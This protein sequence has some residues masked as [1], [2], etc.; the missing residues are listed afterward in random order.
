M[1]EQISMFDFI[2][3]PFQIDKKIRLTELFAGY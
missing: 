3:K 1:T 2:R